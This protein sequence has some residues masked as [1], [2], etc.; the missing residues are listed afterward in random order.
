MY[1]LLF[2]SATM[3]YRTI[4]SVTYTGDIFSLRL[5]ET[6]VYVTMV[7]HFAAS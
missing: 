6:N 5:N 3:T 4:I 2:C 1:S 7:I